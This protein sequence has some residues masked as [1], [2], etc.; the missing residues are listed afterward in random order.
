MKIVLKTPT[1]F[2]A[3]CAQHNGRMLKD[4]SLSC[5]DWDFSRELMDHDEVEVQLEQHAPSWAQP[6]CKTIFI[7]PW[8]PVP[9]CLAGGRYD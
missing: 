8:G 9:D 4:G 1:T 7:T 6:Y 5:D 2:I 3:F